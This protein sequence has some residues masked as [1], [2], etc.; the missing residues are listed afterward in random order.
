LRRV[1]HKDLAVIRIMSCF[2][3]F[4]ETRVSILRSNESATSRCAVRVA[5][6]I[7][8]VVAAAVTAVV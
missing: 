2:L 7:V 1:L 5:A 8:I 3:P 6:V 4:A